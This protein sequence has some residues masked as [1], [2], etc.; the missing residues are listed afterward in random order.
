MSSAARFWLYLAS[1][2]GINALLL[3]FF[4]NRFWYGTDE[5][6][7]AHV[8]E[9]ILQGEVL[10]LDVQDV[11]AGYINFVNAAA[12]RVFGLDLVSLRYPMTA[13]A[14]VQ[15]VLV[16]ILFYRA[17]RRTLALPAAVSITAFGVIQ[18]LNPTSNWYSLFLVVLII[19][20][21]E[22]IPTTVRSRLPIV[23]FLVG[24]LF[25]FRQLSG[26]LVCMSV[27]AYLLFERRLFQRNTEA[28]NPIVARVVIAIMAV[29]LS[30][31]LLRTTDVVGFAL[32]GLCP[33]LILLWLFAKTTINNRQ[34][35]RMLGSLAIGGV[36]ACL[37]LLS[38]HLIH[39]SLQ[40]WFNDTVLSA[41]NLTR[42]G[43]IGQQLY[44][45]FIYVGFQQLG[46]VS[47][48]GE[49]LNAP[50]WIALHL[51]AFANGI[52]VLRS[53]SHTWKA[54]GVEVATTYPLPFVAA[55]YGIVSLHFQ[56]PIYLYYSV[57]LSLVGIMWLMPSKRRVQ[58]AAMSLSLVLAGIAVFYHAGQPLVGT[59]PAFFAGHRNIMSLNQPLSSLPRVSLKIEAEDD[60]RY[61][62]ILKVIE[63]QTRPDDTIFA[64][65]TSAE[66]YF[67]SRRRNPF[68]FYNT[69]LGIRTESD[70]R[71][72][73]E[74][75]IAH[76]PKLV[77]YRSDDKYNTDYSRELMRV[78]AETY[79]FL[80]ETS[81]FAVYR[82]R[83]QP[84]E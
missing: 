81:G 18:F 74:T 39:G 67:I 44:V 64:L 72:V 35:L 63:S 8:A 33:L 71:Q 28:G 53:L 80:G 20:S 15:A 5:G 84:A 46:R 2:S 76:P 43:F 47:T 57:G 21:L 29:G 69:A 83:Q 65:P 27:L 34:A 10:N 58:Y 54:R 36:V 12:L 51:L 68:R 38:Y 59:F 32:F 70:F 73:R 7:Y 23:G 37:P 17:G 50:Y 13:V 30:A 52:L 78:V 48:I 62:D 42:L 3:W 4:H 14:F 25:L 79:E 26:V 77:L 75:M 61:S 24:T 1:A 82:V 55:F 45:K 16:F 9:R 11:H 66:L 40:S 22:W 49:L 60:K 19:C 6:N 31:Y 56:I 41:V